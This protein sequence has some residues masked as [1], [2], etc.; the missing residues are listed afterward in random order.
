M[1]IVLGSLRPSQQTA[2]TSTYLAIRQ[3]NQEK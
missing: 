1:I 2:A 3:A